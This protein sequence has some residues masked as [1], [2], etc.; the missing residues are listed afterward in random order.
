[1]QDETRQCQNCK[2]KIGGSHISAVGQVF[3]SDVCHLR[4]W[5]EEMPNLG[6]RWIDEED[7]EKIEKLSGEDRKEAY[8]KLNRFILDNL[9]T[10]A[11]MLNVRYG[12]EPE[13]P[14][15]LIG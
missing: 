2:N 9:D 6:G 3:C 4:F 10:T 12:S 11:F 8:N 13:K 1:M 5:R 7:I 14:S 15:D